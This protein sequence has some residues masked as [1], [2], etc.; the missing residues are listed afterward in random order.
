MHLLDLLMYFA[1][2]LLIWFI[3]DKLSG[4]ELTNELGGLVGLTIVIV[5]TIIYIVLFCFWPDW[6]WID[7]FHGKINIGITW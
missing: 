1:L 4:G 7:I 2:V 6:N 5:F 3:L